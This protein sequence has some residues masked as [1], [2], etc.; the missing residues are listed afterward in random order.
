MPLKK[1]TSAF[2]TKIPAL[3]LIAVAI[4]IIPGC[5]A[6]TTPKTNKMTYQKTLIASKS[7]YPFVRWR[8]SFNEG[9]EQYTEENCNKAKLIFDTL[10]NELIAK[11]ESASKEEKVELFKKAVL[12]LN[13]LSGEVSDLIE[14]GER[15]DLCELIDQITIA[16]GLN[17]K[18][19]TEG[20]GIADEWREW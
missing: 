18:D 7:K 3:F 12:S 10:I 6:K 11:G 16:A 1:I 4:L 14:T 2:I 15:E 17:P 8:E 5:R 9:L 20:E 19:F 13:H